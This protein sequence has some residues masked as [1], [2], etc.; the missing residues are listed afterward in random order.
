MTD[1]YQFYHQRIEAKYF[2]LLIYLLRPWIIQAL[3]SSTV[4][5][6]ARPTRLRNTVP[7]TSVASQSSGATASAVPDNF[8][9]KQFECLLQS[10]GINP[11]SSLSRPNWSLQPQFH[12]DRPIIVDDA[13]ES[14]ET[15][16]LRYEEEAA[17]R[18]NGGVLR[19]E[20]PPGLL[21]TASYSKSQ[22][23]QMHGYDQV[24]PFP[25]SQYQYSAPSF[26]AAHQS[27][28][29]A[30][31]LN[32]LAF[33]A[34]GSASQYMA[35]VLPTLI[36]YQPESGVCATK[37]M[38]RIS[39]PYDLIAVTSHFYLAFGEQ[40]CAAHAVRDSHDASGFG[41]VVSG[42]AP[43]FEDTR[44]ASVNV[45]LSLL[46]EIP[47][48]QPLAS[49]DIGTFTYHDAQVGPADAA[50]EEVTRPTA[51]Q[52]PEHIDAQKSEQDQITDAATNT[53]GYPPGSQQAAAAT[54]YDPSYSS[55]STNGSM[56]GAYHR[57]SYADDYTRQIPPPIRT[58]SLW[59]SYGASLHSMRSPTMSHQS[60]TTITRPSLS[61]LPAPTSANPQLVRTSTLQSGAPSSS[62]NPYAIYS[63][64]A[65][66]KIA[67]ELESMA[68]GWTKEEWDNR[69]RIVLFRKHQQGST[70][71]ATF[72]PVGVNERPANSICISCIY[73]A[74]KS[75]CF[76]TSVD[77]IYLLEQL[78]AAPARFTVEEKNR[79]RR[80]L[81]GF[82]PLTVSKAKADSEEFFKIIM[83]FPNPK[84]RN[85]EK[86][87]KVFPWKILAPALKK[88]IS[89]YSASPSSTVAP[90]PSHAMLTRVS[91]TSPA[92]Y[93]HPAHT[94]TVPEST[95]G[96]HDPHIA[97]PRSLS[98]ASSSWG[99]YSTRPLSPSLKSHSPTSAG[100][101]IPSMPSYGTPD[102]RHA[103]ASSYGLTPQPPTRW[104]AAT[105]NGYIDAG[106]VSTY[107]SHQHQGQVP[108]RV[109]CPDEPSSLRCDSSFQWSHL[110]R[111]GKPTLLSIVSRASSSDAF[112]TAR[113][114]YADMVEVM[115]GLRHR[116]PSGSTRAEVACGG[117]ELAVTMGGP[118]HD[119]SPCEFVLLMRVFGLWFNSAAVW[120]VAR[121]R[122]CGVG[123]ATQSRLC[124]ALHLLAATIM[125]SHPP[126]HT[127]SWLSPVVIF[128][129]FSTAP[130][131]K[132]L[133]AHYLA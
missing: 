98:G 63:Q 41:Y 128:P 115:R 130:Y 108:S 49:I 83:A 43:S 95:Y 62:F 34:N 30:A 40:R 125:T 45:P 122:C 113:R 2:V 16:T 11:T 64:K 106:A 103:S 23:P 39:A 79:I 127:I 31:Q 110:D 9:C 75:E 15:V 3:E 53:Y 4:L 26:P 73:W 54:A 87:V 133:S 118:P 88:I 66:L 59:G 27:E 126:H 109:H 68:T 32:Q 51:S 28:N 24:R 69:R 131:G 71:T 18:A 37:V 92:L 20:S 114:V 117:A 44:S 70:L 19:E 58:P 94:T 77:T 132:L 129:R 124:A 6:F 13:I 93:P 80:N 29:A 21:T 121:V 57:S 107:T 123:G 91:S 89:K 105:T 119:L 67:G 116:D 85:I 101:R 99:S 38:I 25:D 74:E 76:V 111:G 47:D 12:T 52:S 17:A 90:T 35:P 65:A 14:P 84:P 8:G 112:I 5:A 72:K 60:H 81:E 33:T 61:S 56:I 102:G 55:N 42:D 46:I 7:E 86:D 120:G 97:S 50:A 1:P 104:D 100:I 82:R 48:A 10:S 78:V 22:P 36:S 96:H